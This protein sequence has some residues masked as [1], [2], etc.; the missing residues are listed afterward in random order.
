MTTTYQTPRE[1]VEQIVLRLNARP[2]DIDSATYFE[3]TVGDHINKEL[4]SSLC[5]ADTY[6][7]V[8]TI[9]DEHWLL[10]DEGNSYEFDFVGSG[11]LLEGWTDEMIG[12]DEFTD[13]ERAEFQDILQFL[14]PGIAVVNRELTSAEKEW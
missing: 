12:P 3:L 8:L 6:D 13:E 1:I 5:Y 2:D 10:I 11:Q 4:T 14:L 9:E 7:T